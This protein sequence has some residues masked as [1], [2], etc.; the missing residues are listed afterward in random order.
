MKNAM[1]KIYDTIANSPYNSSAWAET[2]HGRLGLILI[3]PIRGR[4][5]YRVL[6]LL[7][8]KQITT[9]ALKKMGDCQCGDVH[10]I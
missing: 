9:G 1:K 5:R 7:Q 4:H 8:G 2:T 3:P 6:W 10:I